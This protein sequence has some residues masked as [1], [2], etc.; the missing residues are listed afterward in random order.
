MNYSKVVLLVIIF[1]SIFIN[2]LYADPCPKLKV[3]ISIEIDEKA[4]GKLQHDYGT[5]GQSLENQ[6]AAEVERLLQGNSEGFKAY[7]GADVNYQLRVQI[8]TI[9]NNYW[10]N[11]YLESMSTAKY[12]EHVLLQDVSDIHSG[13][14]KIST[15]HGNI[16][17]LINAYEMKH[18]TPVRSPI[19]TV[20]VDP[21][22]ISAEEGNDQCKISVKVLHCNGEPAY[23]INTQYA[24]KVFF[25]KETQRGTVKSTFWKND[26]VFTQTLKN[27]VAEAD[28]QLDHSKGTHPGIDKVEIWTYGPRLKIYRTV[29]TIKIKPS[30]GVLEIEKTAGELGICNFENRCVVQLPF[31]MI[32]SKDSENYEIKG[33]ES[34]RISYKLKCQGCNVITGTFWA[35]ITGGVLDI[36]RKPKN[37]LSLSFEI[38]RDNEVH[39]ITC[40]QPPLVIPRGDQAQMDMKLYNW[41]LI[42]GYSEQIGVFKYTIHLGR[43]SH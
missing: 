12:V 37:P 27:G 9:G 24:Q 25:K 36:K 7:S 5:T 43:V 39:K 2:N 14:T 22:E 38:F 20:A 19:I 18:T 10:L 28:Y 15:E 13:L 4:M 17:A 21:D 23:S 32:E 41:P 26:F 3:K 16:E 31:K 40:R 8:N 30:K 34:N 33:G 35:K 42:D 6:I 29:A 11:T 1:F